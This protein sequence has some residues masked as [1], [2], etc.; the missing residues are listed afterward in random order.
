MGKIIKQAAVVTTPEQKNKDRLIYLHMRLKALFNEL[1]SEKITPFTTYMLVTVNGMLESVNP[2]S[3][4]GW[5]NISLDFLED[6]V[7]T[8]ENHLLQYRQK[9]EA[10]WL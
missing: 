8:L 1:V 2:D 7:V 9:E 3:V 4:A 6:H 10:N 5:E